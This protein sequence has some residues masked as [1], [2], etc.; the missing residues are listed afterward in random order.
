MSNMCLIIFE[1]KAEV[2]AQYALSLNSVQKADD[3]IQDRNRSINPLAHT[4]VTISSINLCIKMRR[5]L[6]LT[7]DTW[8]LVSAFKDRMF[9]IENGKKVLSSSAAASKI[10]DEDEAQKTHCCQLEMTDLLLYSSICPQQ[11]C[12]CV[13]WR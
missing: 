3:P 5:S 4:C 11:A 1:G 7:T 10:D 8:P 6:L 2:Q 13:S 9:A 12:R